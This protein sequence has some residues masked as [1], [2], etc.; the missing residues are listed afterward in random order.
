MQTCLLG[1]AIQQLDLQI[2]YRPGTK[3]QNADALSHSRMSRPVVEGK[4]AAKDG[5]GAANALGCDD[6]RQELGAKQD[7]RGGGR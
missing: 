1:L 7:G 2:Q 4:V 3:N 5:E 6:S